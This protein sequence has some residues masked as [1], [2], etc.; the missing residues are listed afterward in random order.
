[1]WEA[2]LSGPLLLV[3]GGSGIVPVRAM[4]RHWAAAERPVAVRVRTRPALE[5]LIYREELLRLA[6]HDEL[7]LRIAPTRTW[8]DDWRGHRGRIDRELLAEVAW[9]PEERPRVYVCGPS[10]FVEAAAAGLVEHG[11]EP[12]LV[13][14]ER[15]GPSG[16]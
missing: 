2:S 9:R 13:K 11:Y 3:A 8:P 14:T 5:D 7:D 16:A 15:F 1:M 6:A 12:G 4:L 10:G